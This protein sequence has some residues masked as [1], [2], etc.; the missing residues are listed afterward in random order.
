MK[1]SILIIAIITTINSFGQNQTN[2]DENKVPEYKLPEVLVS[3]KGE[4]ITN[5]RDWEKKRRPEILSLFE[6][7]IYG[8]IPG[9]LKLAS[10]KVV[11]QS[12]NAFSNKAIRKQVVLHFENGGKELNVGLLIY[13]PKNVEKAPVFVSYNFWGNQTVADDPEI[14]LT[15]SWINNNTNL[16]YINNKVSEKSRG[17]GKK[18][19]SVEKLIDSGYG[20]ATMYAGDIDP[21]KSGDLGPDFSDGVHP[22]LYKKGQSKPLDNEWGAIAAWAWGLSRAMDYLEEDPNVDSK[23]VIVFGHSRHGKAALWAGAMDQ[24]F[25]MVVSNNSGCGGAALSRRRYGERLGGINSQ[26]K[27]WLCGNSRTF[28]YNE[29]TLPID[30]H[31]LIALIAPRPVYVASADEDLW[32]DPKGEFLS[33]Y[34]ATPVYNLYGKQGIS[35]PQMPDIDRPVMTYIGYHIRAGKHAVTEFDWDQYLRFADIHLKKRNCN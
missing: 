27:H 11:E 32:A 15:E 6:Q 7:N 33:A 35:T 22:L 19:L 4:T 10:Y 17:A 29:D 13:L 24:R 20:L 31:Q 25:A 9:K 28:D 30:Q 14:L 21:D 2:Y 3:E 12:D 1:K 26:F 5:Y 34:Y 23:N 18:L 8:K 16:G